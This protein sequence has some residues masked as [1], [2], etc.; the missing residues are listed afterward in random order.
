MDESSRPQSFKMRLLTHYWFNWCL[1]LNLPQAATGIF[2]CVFDDIDSTWNTKINK[3]WVA[4]WITESCVGVGKC[5][6]YSTF[7]P[8]AVVDQTLLSINEGYQEKANT[9]RKFKAYFMATCWYCN[10]WVFYCI[11]IFSLLMALYVGNPPVYIVMYLYCVPLINRT[12]NVF[13][14]KWLIGC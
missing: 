8:H 3:E 12:K 10:T 2:V 5:M 1:L 4:K 11:Y 7:N 9:A 6:A 13:Y 14:E